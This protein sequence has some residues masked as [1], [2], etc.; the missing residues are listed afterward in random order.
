MD[1]PP[2][3]APSSAPSSAASSAPIPG[4]ASV[5]P[6]ESPPLQ[7]AKGRIAAIPTILAINSFLIDID[8][9]SNT[10]YVTKDFKSNH[11]SGEQQAWAAKRRAP[12]S[13]RSRQPLRD[14]VGR[15]SPLVDGMDD[16][17]LSVLAVPPVKVQDIH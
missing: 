5:P 14:G 2:L 1:D 11:K 4:P 17:R 7:P 12:G 3:S 16:E 6:P 15:E 13:E 8:A 9:S 10:G